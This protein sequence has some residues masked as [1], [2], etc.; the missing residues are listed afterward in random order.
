MA[1]TA[2]GHQIPGTIAE[3]R[4]PGMPV[5]RCGGVPDC[6][7]CKTEAAAH[8]TPQTGVKWDIDANRPIAESQSFEEQTPLPAGPVRFRKDPIEFEAIQ[9]TGDNLAEVQRFTGAFQHEEKGEVP[10]FQ[11]E[12]NPDLTVGYLWVAANHAYLEIELGEWV[13]RDE[14]GFYPCKDEIIRAN[15]TELTD[16]M[17]D[18]LREMAEPKTFQQELV[19]LLNKHSMEN[20]SGTPDWILAEFLRKCLEGWDL[21]VRLRS[22]WRGEDLELPALQRLDRDHK[23]IVKLRALLSDG[24]IRL[25]PEFRNT[26]LYS[27]L[28]DS[29]REFDEKQTAKKEER[30]SNRFERYQQKGLTEDG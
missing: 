10:V 17:I 1:F 21:G 13:I 3:E 30:P 23:T 27:E 16:D 5:A 28:V 11:T 18:L 29:A 12:A 7:Q 14:L 6:G 26:E 19:S 24:I 15:N 20:Y 22:E 4:P 2:H 8:T 25:N 9:W